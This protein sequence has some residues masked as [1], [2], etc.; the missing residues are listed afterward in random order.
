MV[1]VTNLNDGVER[2]DVV[3]NTSLMVF[4]L[5]PHTEYDVNV[6]AATTAGTGPP[7][8]PLTVHTHEDGKFTHK[9]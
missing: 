4:S 1:T 9:N 5:E 3:S 7:T 6:L 8:N 2:E